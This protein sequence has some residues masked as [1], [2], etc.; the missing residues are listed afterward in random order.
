MDFIFIVI[1]LCLIG[2]FVLCHAYLLD[3]IKVSISF[4][5]LVNV[6][7]VNIVI[8]QKC[9]FIDCNGS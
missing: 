9:I 4:D 7:P 8:Q 2:N 3:K 6:E 1:S 5:C